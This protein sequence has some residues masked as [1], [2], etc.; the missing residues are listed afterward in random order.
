MQQENFHIFGPVPSRRLGYSLGVDILPLKTCNLN[1]VYCELGRTNRETNRRKAWVGADVILPEIERAL[2]NTGRIDFITF[3]GSGEPT[4]NTELGTMI[5]A[6]K[7]MTPIPVAVITNGTLLWLPE[8]RND[9]AEADLV[10]PSLDAASRVAFKKINRP[11]GTLELEKIIDGL[12]AFRHEY[13][14]PIWLEILL[15]R[16]FN[17]N[18]EEIDALVQAVRR[19]QPDKVQLNT[20]V[21]PPAEADI[22]PLSHAELVALQRKFGDRAE[23][24]A[25][26]EAGRQM[27]QSQDVEAEVCALCARRPV[28]LDEIVT[29]LGFSKDEVDR[30]IAALVFDGRLAALPHGRKVYYT[31]PRDRARDVFPQDYFAE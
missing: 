21:R 14:G 30:A 23:V 19:I 1:C 15:A 9:V 6:I 17:D 13:N 27:N 28:T 4:L 20:V 11:H 25:H 8:V 18:P 22:K 3:S 7:K 24:I 29:S 16:G 2:K 31:V 10:L 5:R 12:V 26:F